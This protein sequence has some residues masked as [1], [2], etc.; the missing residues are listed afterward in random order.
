VI[1]KVWRVDSPG[2]VGLRFGGSFR[3]GHT[4][5]PSAASAP[6]SPPVWPS[7]PPPPQQPKLKGGSSATSANQTASPPVTQPR[8]HRR[9]LLRPAARAGVSADTTAS[10]EALGV[11]E[12]TSTGRAKTTLARAPALSRRGGGSRFA[13]ARKQGGDR[14]SGTWFAAFCERRPHPSTRTPVSPMPEQAAT[15]DDAARAP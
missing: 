3:G 7:V 12:R 9:L 11:R 6:P 8:R 10:A 4:P 1:R 15:R 14:V 5:R 2:R 13:I